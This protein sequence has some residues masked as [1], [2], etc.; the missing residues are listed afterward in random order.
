VATQVIP[1][2]AAR[3][4]RLCRQWG[5]T[6]EEHEPR[7]DWNLVY[8][9]R[10]GDEPCVLRICGPGSD[11]D[12]EA[13][14]LQAWA[15]DGAVRPLE[16]DLGER[17]MR[18]ERLAADR[19]LTDLP[20]SAAAE[21]AGRL[22]RTLAVP[23]PAGLPRLVD[24]ALAATEEMVIQQR[25][26]GNP[27]PAAILTRAVDI[28]SDLSLDAGST[29]VH[30]DLHY[31]NILA[32]ARQPWLA[33]D[34]KPFTGHPERSIAELLWTRL[35]EAADDAA[36]HTLLAMIVAAARL[37]PERAQ[38]WAVV[39]ATSYWLWGLENGL[40]EDPARC[41]RLLDALVPARKL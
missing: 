29:L 19:S 1:D 26:L 21:I 6:P 16:V 13:T 38:A 22:I 18:L 24:V 28:A 7:G 12:D 11:V 31:G 40:T 41:R 25:R 27:V 30:G 32:G 4:D 10:R 36:I 33:I 34:P 2:A 8:L 9:V 3:V 14:A 17:A 35:D 15:G 37:D 5:L 39:R 20:L 23:A